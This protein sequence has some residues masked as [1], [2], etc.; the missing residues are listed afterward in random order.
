VQSLL[1]G[2]EHEAG[3]RRPAYPPADDAAGIGVDY[4]GHVD[5]ARLG[6]HVGEV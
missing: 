5:E 3:M 2:I 4:E 1:Q 6:R